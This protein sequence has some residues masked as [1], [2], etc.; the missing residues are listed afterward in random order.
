MDTPT[1]FLHLLPHIEPCTN[2]RSRVELFRGL[3]AAQ[4]VPHLPPEVVEL[5]HVAFSSGF[6]AIRLKAESVASAMQISQ[7]VLRAV[8]IENASVTS[9]GTG[10]WGPLYRASS[11][12]L[13]CKILLWYVFVARLTEFAQLWSILL[14]KA[15]LL[16]DILK[17]R[18][19]FNVRE[20]PWVVQPPPL[21]TH[22]CFAK[23]LNL[24][25]QHGRSPFSYKYELPLFQRR[26]QF[27]CPGNLWV[28]RA[29]AAPVFGAL[30]DDRTWM[31]T[32]EFKASD[33][34]VL[35]PSWSEESGMIVL[36]LGE[37]GR[38]TAVFHQ[39]GVKI[40]RSLGN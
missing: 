9:R 26:A 33:R 20:G 27:A 4:L 23:A 21:V 14:P 17:E 10:K 22:A 30:S 36:F 1:S 32:P 31:I 37:E 8:D 13:R 18:C 11:W 38:V 12:E 7:T 6:A 15:V 19:G 2:F 29:L 28:A 16:Q 34:S 3:S 25:T 35:L 40:P 39:D 5:R 24:A